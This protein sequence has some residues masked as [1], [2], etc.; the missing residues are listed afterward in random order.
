[1][2]IRHPRTVACGKGIEFGR[3][4]KSGLCRFELPLAQQCHG[5]ISISSRETGLQ[6]K[7]AVIEPVGLIPLIVKPGTCSALHCSCFSV[8]RIESIAALRCGLHFGIH[9]TTGNKAKKGEMAVRLSNSAIGG[10]GIGE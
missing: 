1:M 6:S 2:D 5:T 3:A 4:A 7:R 9:G 8:F 10:S